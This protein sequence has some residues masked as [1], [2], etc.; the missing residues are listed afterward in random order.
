MPK[1][2]LRLIY[3]ALFL[4]LALGLG[5]L[6]YGAMVILSLFISGDVNGC[7][8][9]MG[10]CFPKPPDWWG[11]VVW[12]VPI[13]V[14]FLLMLWGHRSIRRWER[15]APDEGRDVSNVR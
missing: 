2:G 7:Q 1:L 10:W 4:T 6:A 3:Y 13:A 15:S 14:I 12:L 5:A 8:S 11:V 9:G